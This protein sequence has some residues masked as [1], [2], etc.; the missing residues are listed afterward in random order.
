MKSVSAKLL[1]LG[2]I[3][4]AVSCNN[5]SEKSK[6]NLQDSLTMEKSTTEKKINS[7]KFD[8]NAIPVSHQELG[9]FPYFSLP[10]GLTDNNQ[11]VQR[12]FDRIF[13]AIKGEMIPLEG[14][15]WK[16][17]IS[18]KSNDQWSLPFFEKSYDDAIKAVGGIQ[19]FDGKITDEEYQK[20]YQKAAYLGEA[21]SIGYSDQNIKSYIIRSSDEGDVYIQI[22]GTTAG[23]AINILQK[24][25]FKQTIT[26]VKSD[27]IQNELHNKGKAVL[28]INFDTDKATLQTDGKEAVAEIAK[29]LTAD[30]SL[31][32]TIN[33]YSDNTGDENHNLNL[34]KE[35]AETVKAE[36][37]K[38]GIEAK[39]LTSEGF[40]Q[41]NPIADNNS[42][43]GKAQNRRVELV[44]K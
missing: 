38:S 2:L 3:L 37:I 18:P 34:S 8:V 9:S 7:D 1:I 6:D 21:G 24:E 17:D 41:N 23:G 12:K 27:Q 30:K 31:N 19:I 15:V 11:P 13:F 32:I 20:Y 36:L 44:K 28:H 16:A 26:M 4:I 35:R 39:R 40:G 29:A 5:T 10:E 43:E 14:K 42:E 33:G 22:S 25:A